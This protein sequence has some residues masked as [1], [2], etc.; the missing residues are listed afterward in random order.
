MREKAESTILTFQARF[1]CCL[2][3]EHALNFSE[4]FFST[5]VRSPTFFFP[6]HCCH[7]KKTA[8]RDKHGG[9]SSARSLTLKSQLDDEQ[10]E[11]FTEAFQAFDKNKDGRVNGKELQALM[12]YMGTIL[13]D[14]ETM[15]MIRECGGALSFLFLIFND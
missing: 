8:K 2:K 6:C 10:R 15:E 14:A 12:R 9:N 3:A 11:E 13:S 5:R 1:L 4:T 7:Q